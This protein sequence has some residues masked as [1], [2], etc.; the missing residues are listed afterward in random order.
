MRKGG[1][2]LKR[3]GGSFKKNEALLYY[4]LKKR[5]TDFENFKG[6]GKDKAQRGGVC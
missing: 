4:T 6:V 5:D 2:M 1:K 3:V